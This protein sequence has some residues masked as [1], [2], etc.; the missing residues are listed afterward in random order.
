MK[1]MLDE[2]RD[3]TYAKAWIAENE[4]GRPWFNETRAREQE[5]PIEEV[6]AELRRMMPF[7][8]PVTIRPDGVLV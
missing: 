2:I 3:G 4:A 8:K 1:Q 6:G 7:L 5:H